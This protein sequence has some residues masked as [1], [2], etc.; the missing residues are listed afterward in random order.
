VTKNAESLEGIIDKHLR[1]ISREKQKVLDLEK[2]L[3]Q[4]QINKKEVSEVLSKFPARVVEALSKE[5]GVLAKS[6]SAG[7]ITQTKFVLLRPVFLPR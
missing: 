2:K 7:G 5:D 1:E 4:A 3:A 6:L